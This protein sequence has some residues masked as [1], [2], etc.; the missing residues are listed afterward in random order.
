MLF[1][2]CHDIFTL[3]LA[4]LVCCASGKSRPM[5]SSFNMQILC[6]NNSICICNHIN[7]HHCTLY[8][9][10]IHIATYIFVFAFCVLNILN[11]NAMLIFHFPFNIQKVLPSWT[12]SLICFCTFCF[13]SSNFLSF[14]V[15]ILTVSHVG[16]WVC[17]ITQR[18]QFTNKSSISECKTC[19]GLF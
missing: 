18:C 5:H 14:P 19:Y 2:Q 13:S 1:V 15:C 6:R 8:N 16:L 11:A 4:K 10:Q 3:E 7:P 12:N 17:E 9:I